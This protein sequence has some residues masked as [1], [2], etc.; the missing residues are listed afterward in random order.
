ME[1]IRDQAEEETQRSEH[2]PVL[3]KVGPVQMSKMSPL[4]PEQTPQQS[5]DRASLTRKT[6]ETG[7][8]SI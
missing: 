1:N 6:G 4:K 5:Q 3:T 2:E 8:T 7:H